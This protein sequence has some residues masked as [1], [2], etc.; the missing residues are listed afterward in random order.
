MGQ[1][2]LFVIAEELTPSEAK[3][4]QWEL[5]DNKMPYFSSFHGPF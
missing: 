3:F 1:M 4:D 5:E 2:I